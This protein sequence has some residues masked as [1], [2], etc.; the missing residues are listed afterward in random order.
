VREVP[1]RYFLRFV[2]RAETIFISSDAA[3]P[4]GRWRGQKAMMSRVGRGAASER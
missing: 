3:R 4:G 2:Q 1:H